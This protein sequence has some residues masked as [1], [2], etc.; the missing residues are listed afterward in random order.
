MASVNRIVSHLNSNGLKWHMVH[1]C[2]LKMLIWLKVEIMAKHVSMHTLFFNTHSVMESIG[3]CWLLE[4]ILKRLLSFPL[5]MW[6]YVGVTV[7]VT[8]TFM[9]PDVQINYCFQLPF[10]G[11]LVLQSFNLCALHA[12]IAVQYIFIQLFLQE[13]QGDLCSSSFKIYSLNNPVM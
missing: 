12:I 8:S 13:V 10:W 2:S 4:G 6:C 3:V 1:L 11:I 5:G 7:A 9:G